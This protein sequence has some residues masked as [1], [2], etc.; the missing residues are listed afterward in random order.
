ML[1]R[2]QMD[3]RRATLT[4]AL[5]ALVCSLAFGLYAAEQ[6]RVFVIEKGDWV[7][8]DKVVKTDE[9]W[10]AQLTPEQYRVTRQQGTERP[11][12][13]VFHDTK[14]EGLYRCVCCDLALFQSDT[15]FDSGTG[16]PSFFKPVALSNIEEKEDFS[17]GMRRV[18]V[19]CARCDAHLGHVFPDGPPPTGKR[20]CIN[21][22]A[23]TF[24]SNDS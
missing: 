5:T 14:E 11:F 16:W 20:Y 4:L 18:E 7:V 19:I 15:K 22:A 17:H 23:L 21:S 3:G 8:M 13:G 2:L 1:G 10:R 24:E 6:V 9:E 12:C